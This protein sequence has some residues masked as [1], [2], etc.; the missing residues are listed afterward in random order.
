MI[1][2]VIYSM[3]KMN[4]TVLVKPVPYKS[5]IDNDGN[6]VRTKIKNIINK[7]DKCA[8]EEA[9]KIKKKTNFFSYIWTSRETTQPRR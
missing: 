4:I 2:G 8:I 7:D 1:G 9:L 6:V 5:V 3:K